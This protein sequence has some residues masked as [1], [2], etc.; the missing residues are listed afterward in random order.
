[1]DEFKGHSR[2]DLVALILG[3]RRE[4]HQ[5]VTELASA[6]GMFDECVQERDAARLLNEL[7]HFD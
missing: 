4:L 3:L 2:E 1:M 5:S 7:C 6:R